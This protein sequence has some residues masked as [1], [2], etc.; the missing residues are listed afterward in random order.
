M[1]KEVPTAGSSSELERGEVPEVAAL[2]NALTSLFNTLEM[3]QNAYAVRI[4]MDKSIISRYLRGR[5]VATEDFIDRLVR[6]VEARHGA[7]VQPEVRRRMT[8]L[9][10]D[11]LKV[12]DPATYELEALR[13]EMLDSGRKVQMLVRHQEAL[14][15][16]LEKRESAI[17]TVQEELETVRRGW[18]ADLVR[19]ERAEIELREQADKHSTERERLAEEIAR[20]KAELSEIARLKVGAERRCADLEEQVKAMEEELAAQPGSTGELLL[21]LAALK[22][23]LAGLIE[24]GEQREAS[25]EVVEAAWGRSIGEVAELLG[26]LTERR[27]YGRTDRLIAEV[28]HSRDV[29]ELAEFG[30]M[31]RNPK[32]YFPVVLIQETVAV[33]SPQEIFRLHTEWLDYSSPINV[34]ESLLAFLFRSRRDEG[35]VV[36]TLTLLDPDDAVTLATLKAIR[37]RTG[38]ERRYIRIVTHLES[39]G[40]SDLATA[41][42][43]NLLRK[44]YRLNSLLRGF[45]D[46]QC[47]LF[48]RVVLRSELIETIVHLLVREF[49]LLPDPKADDNRLDHRVALFADTLRDSG[50]LSEVQTVI[51]ATAPRTDGATSLLSYLENRSTPA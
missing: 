44:T 39:M 6:E 4:S 9:R 50:R 24:T 42:C 46:Q 8:Q 29:E 20:L 25:R 47:A 41:L 40:C 28:V 5:R 31:I 16:L 22:E 48:A 21:P 12:T 10:L 49:N 23:Q 51:A 38:Y 45:T 1:A 14:H 26:W 34:K 11:A 27:D 30:R 15:D 2:G 17:R 43:T 35:D 19:A 18:T 32:G 13:A 33:R 7:S 37:V 3:T 36:A